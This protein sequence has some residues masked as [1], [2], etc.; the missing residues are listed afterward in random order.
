MTKNKIATIYFL[1]K[2]SLL[3]KGSVEAIIETARAG[4]KANF[5]LEFWTNMDT[6][7]QATYD[8]LKQ[9]GVEIK[10]YRS[11][12]KEE[13]IITGIIE[14]FVKLGDDGD[15][16]AYAAASDILRIAI[17]NAKSLEEDPLY[18][19][20]DCNDTLFEAD[21]VQE[22][23]ILLPEKFN[24][25]PWGLAFE[26]SP[27]DLP[28]DR[29]IV[30]KQNNPGFLNAFFFGY[31]ELLCEH[32]SKY[33]HWKTEALKQSFIT[34][35]TCFSSLF[36]M[37]EG[38]IICNPDAFSIDETGRI[39]ISQRNRH[40]RTRTTALVGYTA[41]SE[42]INFAAYITSKRIINKSCSWRQFDLCLDDLDSRECYDR[43]LQK[44]VIYINLH[45]KQYRFLSMDLA[46]GNRN[47]VTV[48]FPK[49]INLADVATMLTDPDLKARLSADAR[50]HDPA[51]QKCTF[52]STSDDELDD[53]ERND[54]NN[55]LDSTGSNA[56]IAIQREQRNIPLP[57]A[58][59]CPGFFAQS[60]Q[61]LLGTGIHPATIGTDNPMQV[62]NFDAP[63]EDM[64][65][66]VMP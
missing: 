48:E 27:G 25:N 14:Y 58:A 38:Q 62:D 34:T 30:R 33:K 11:L 42:D 13:P 44:G 22:E 29:M 66:P 10:D 15:I 31:F 49:D 12:E 40:L 7:D 59:L 8:I 61:R 16:A 39:V 21:L 43:H 46:F 64:G 1:K 60:A 24:Q 6:L 19:Y 55:D 51:L 53:S 47:E 36:R 17:A 2:D 52:I 5:S 57:V 45:K 9:K 54:S 26:H 32:Y 23:L 3:P 4:S 65:F 56:Y 63:P 35:V 28:N 50:R 41:S 37:K 18:I 20:Y